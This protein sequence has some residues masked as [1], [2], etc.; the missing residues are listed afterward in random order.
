MAAEQ[1]RMAKAASGRRRFGFAASWRQAWAMLALCAAPAAAR[2]PS[3]PP[4][5]VVSNAWVRALRAP[6]PAAAYFTLSNTS[7]R[8]RV[9]VGSA[10]PD[11][12]ALMMHQ[13]RNL[14]GAE[15]MIMVSRRI[16]PPH[17]QIV[18]APGGYH[19]MCLSPSEAVRPG[20]W[21]PITLRFADGQRLLVRFPV[22]AP[23]G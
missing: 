20:G 3:P 23:G 15:S 21:M 11:C 12:G 17:G 14:G 18:F 8:P 5:L 6:T 16:V 13:S 1:I 19:L 10:S 22:R 4:R 2:G 9:L 7:D